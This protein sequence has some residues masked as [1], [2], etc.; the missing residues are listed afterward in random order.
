MSDKERAYLKCLKIRLQQR[1]KENGEKKSNCSKMTKKKKV[2]ELKIY[3]ENLLKND[4]KGCSKC[5]YS[6]KGCKNCKE[7]QKE[8]T[9]SAQRVERRAVKRNG[10]KKMIRKYRRADYCG[11]CNGCK[12][13]QGAW[14]EECLPASIAKIHNQKKSAMRIE[15]C[16]RKRNNIDSN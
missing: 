5:R 15:A 9:G 14:A 1:D 7:K 12:H 3:C 8:D 11:E 2:E 16:E 6:K 13:N 4:K 10:V